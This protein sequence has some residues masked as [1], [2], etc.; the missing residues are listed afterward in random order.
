[1]RRTAG[2]EALRARIVATRGRRL[3][4]RQLRLWQLLLDLPEAEV[5]V[6]LAEPA[7]MVWD[8]RSG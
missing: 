1:L 5:T 4:P 6:W 3:S 2:D 7:R 8:R